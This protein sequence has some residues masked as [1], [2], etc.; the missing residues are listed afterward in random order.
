MFIPWTPWSRFLAQIDGQLEDADHRRRGTRTTSATSP[1]QWSLCPMAEQNEV[2]R[3]QRLELRKRRRTLD[4][5]PRIE[6]QA[7]AGGSP[8][9]KVEWLQRV[10]DK[11]WRF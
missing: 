6:Q 5:E 4:T 10:M 1:R 2:D 7:F 8:T 3:L 9:M 11:T